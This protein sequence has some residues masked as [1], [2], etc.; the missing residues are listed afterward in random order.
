MKIHTVRVAE[1][2]AYT[3]ITT[4][5]QCFHDVVLNGLVSISP[6]SKGGLNNDAHITLTYAREHA[7]RIVIVF[8]TPGLA[9]KEREKLIEAWKEFGSQQNTSQQERIHFI[10]TGVENNVQ[11]FSAV[12]LAELLYVGSP[13]TAPT[14]MVITRM[15]FEARFSG[16]IIVNFDIPELENLLEEHDKL[17]KAWQAYKNANTT[18]PQENY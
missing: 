2:A 1:K 8:R 10:K 18:Q 16:G 13:I 9:T 12:D 7:E 17:M 15:G 3:N 6:V 11:L 14:F 4:D 5:G